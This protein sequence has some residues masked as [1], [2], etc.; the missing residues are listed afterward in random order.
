MK[1]EENKSL[2]L[3][4]L[5]SSV[6]IIVSLSLV[7]F[8]LGVLGLL[9]INSQKISNYVKENIGFTIMLNDDINDVE[10]INLEKELISANFVKNTR[11][12]SKSEAAQKLQ[13]ELGEDF[14]SFLGYNPLL[15]SIE[16]T[17]NAKYTSVD[18]LNLIAENL[19]KNTKIYEIFYQ[20]DLIKKLNENV[21]KLSLFL[22]VFC[23]LLFF[24]SFT[25]I[26]N[27]IRLSIYSKRFLIRTMRLVGATNYFI[28]K[29][30]LEKSIYEGVYSSIFAVFLLMGSINLVQKEIASILNINDI[31]NIGIVFIL[32]FTFGLLISFFS[33][34]FA[35]KKHIYQK[36][37]KIY[38]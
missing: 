22:I 3:K 11:F 27:T 32:I 24:I 23:L 20:K 37:N 7:L 38:K 5:S 33:T 17:L 18:S 13:K 35:V 1:T 31:K 10:R 2:N 21:N 16:I 8:M 26:N 34:Y 4:I 36:Q 28:Q 25:L 9:L 19:S 12:V 30:F 15:N 29:P 6:S 14:I